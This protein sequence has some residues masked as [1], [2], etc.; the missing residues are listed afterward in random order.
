MKSGA[1]N[2]NKAQEELLQALKKQMR[3]QFDALN[4][5][6]EGRWNTR[7]ICHQKD[8]YEGPPRHVVSP[9][10]VPMFG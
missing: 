5:R 3:D 1:E 2:A 8:E 6:L 7:D 9:K 10:N 4:K